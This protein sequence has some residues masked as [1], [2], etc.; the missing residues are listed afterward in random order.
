MQIRS[1]ISY[2]RLL[3]LYILERSDLLCVTPLSR[4]TRL[5]AYSFE[6]CKERKK[7]ISPRG[8]T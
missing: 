4:N 5:I 2:S 7:N 1:H 8:P 6:P 3:N